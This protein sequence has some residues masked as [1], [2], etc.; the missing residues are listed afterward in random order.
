[1]Q[2]IA[3]ILKTGSE[4]LNLT[5]SQEQIDQLLGLLQLLQKWNQSF[6]LTAVNDLQRLAIWHVLD[7]LALSPFLYGNR[8]LDVGTGAGFP[9]L[10]LAILHSD[11]YFVLLDSNLKKI[12]FVRQVVLELGLDNVEVMHRRLQEYQPDCQFDTVLARAVSSLADMVDNVARLVTGGGRLL[13]PKGQFPQAELNE[14]N[15]YQYSVLKLEIPGMD[16]Q[17]HLVRIDC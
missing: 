3:E 11:Q 15:D 2:A 5:A 14:L 1:L 9:G 4:T 17:R 10:P 12:R 6:N 13:L 7:S 16:A 8:M